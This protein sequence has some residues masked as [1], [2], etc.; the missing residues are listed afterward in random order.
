MEKTN[1]ILIFPR[2]EYVFVYLELIMMESQ[3]FGNDQTYLSS[4]LI[5]NLI[6][7]SFFLVQNGFYF[8]KNQQLFFKEKVRDADEIKNCIKSIEHF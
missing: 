5:I 3:I 6:Q 7:L 2:S 1:F 4:Y 8:F